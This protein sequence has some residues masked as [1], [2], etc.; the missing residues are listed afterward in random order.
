MAW[1]N[2]HVCIM[3]EYEHMIYSSCMSAFMWTA[4]C[5]RVD[6]NSNIYE[7]EQG[8]TRWNYQYDVAVPW[9]NLEMVTTDS[10]NSNSNQLHMYVPVR[11]LVYSWVSV[12]DFLVS[13]RRCLF[14]IEVLILA[15]AR[16]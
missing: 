15:L 7:Y 8:I 1:M 9:R 16:S 2:A 13:S 4:R 11:F 6:D 3:Y 10:S 14:V 5:F 12:L